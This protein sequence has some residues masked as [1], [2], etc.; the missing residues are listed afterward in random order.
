MERRLYYITLFSI[1]AGIVLSCLLF[2]LFYHVE[3]KSIQREFEAEIN[4]KAELLSGSLTLQFEALYGVK[5]AF[6]NYGV[7]LPD[8][9]SVLATTIL[10]RHPQLEALEWVPYVAGKQRTEQESFVARRLPGFE[11]SERVASGDMVRA[12]DRPAYFP[13]YY[14]EPLAGNEA[15]LGYDL[16]S[17]SIRLD[18]I[19]RA[20]DSGEMQLS[21]GLKLLQPV[22][23]SGDNSGLLSFLPVYRQPEPESVYRRRESLLGFVVGVFR[24][25]EILPVTYL[26]GEEESLHYSLIDLSAP[27]DNQVLYHYP[28]MTKQ[29]DNLLDQLTYTRSVLQQGGRRWV[30]EATPTNAY[31]EQRRTVTPWLV[32]AAGSLFFGI[33]SWLGSTTLK[34]SKLFLA[35]IDSKNQQLNTANAKLERLTKTDCLTGI[36]NRRFFDE[37]YDQEFR[38]AQREDLPLALLIVDIDYFKEFNDNY[39]HQAGDRCLKLVAN[40]LERV[41]KRPADM[42]ARIGGEEFGILLPN[43]TDGEVVAKQCR[44][45]VERLNIEHRGAGE[46]AFVTI[47][48]GVA[49]AESVRD[50]TKDTLFNMADTALYQAKKGGRNRVRAIKI[51]PELADEVV[52]MC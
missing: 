20:R 35:E 29:N 16:G 30:L 49:S 9:F 48:V 46:L 40:E 27:A 31:F 50:Q 43:T 32:F 45:A 39:G 15:F 10:S 14:L 5:L 36:A 2:G 17:N 13:V 22:G 25:G 52:S 44:A 42:I 41:L 51:R 34:R 8:E 6:D 7:L 11:F 12:T 33:V 19:R 47:S 4:K 18:A 21:E 26:A 37:T 28:L 23:G 24:I 1:V 38:R 3:T